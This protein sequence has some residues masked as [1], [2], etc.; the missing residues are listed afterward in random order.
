MSAEYVELAVWF[1]VYHYLAVNIAWYFPREG[2]S[3]QPASKF[4]GSLVGSFATLPGATDTFLREYMLASALGEVV[5]ALG[6]VRPTLWILRSLASDT[7]DETSTVSLLAS[8]EAASF[9]GVTVGFVTEQQLQNGTAPADGQNVVIIVPNSTFV[10]DA[11]V[12][13]LQLWPHEAVVLASNTTSACLRYDPSGVERPQSTK[14]RHFLDNLTA[15]PIVPAPAMHAMLRAQV[16]PRLAQPPAWCV[17]AA[18]PAAGPAFAVLCRF[19]TIEDKAGRARL[20]GIVINLD[21]RPLTVAVMM[22]SPQHSGGVAAAKA[23]ELRSGTTVALGNGGKLL[24]AGQVL[25]LELPGA[26]VLPWTARTSSR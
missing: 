4:A 13:A 11:T 9:L 18:S 17:A 20:V 7:Q 19:T 15:L 23:V 1:T 8:F 26:E 3:P 10:D 12:A 16:L 6:R 21:A 5:A 25:V 2:L 14:L 22:R 24:Q